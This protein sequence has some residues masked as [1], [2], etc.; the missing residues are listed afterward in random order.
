M[1]PTSCR[2]QI[3]QVCCMGLPAEMLMP[4]LLPMLRTLVPAESAGFF[5]VDSSGDMQNLYAE[6]MLPMQKMQLYFDHFYEGGEFDFKRGFLKRAQATNAVS[7]VPVSDSLKRSAYYNEILRDLDAHHVMH[8]I[9]REHG[10]VLGQISLYRPPASPAFASAD[11]AELESVLH[12]IAHAVAA[13]PAGIQ[14]MT[15]HSSAQSVDLDKNHAELMLDT[16]D[17][18]MALIDANGGLVHA[19]DAA[20]R[21][22]L[23]AI[24]GQFSGSGVAAL[25]SVTSPALEL[26]RTLAIKLL[27]EPEVVPSI[28]QKSRWGTIVL[29]AYHLGES[30]AASTPIAIR[31]SRQEPMILRFAHAM[32]SVGLSPQMQEIALNLARGKSN[33]EIAEAMSLSA[34]TVSYHIKMLFQKLGTHSREETVKHILAQ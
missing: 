9:V 21:L 34:N 2:A 8:G 11:H 20:R 25:S 1:K 26:L 7:T 24:D 15:C 33:H 22:L 4:R 10:T 23:Q 12:Y 27:R 17:D 29:R 18:A 16:D 3:R 19:S 5:W 14:K 13:S 28:A 30:T 31:I 32:Q 6:R